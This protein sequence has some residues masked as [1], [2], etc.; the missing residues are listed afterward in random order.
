MW[1]NELESI[2]LNKSHILEWDFALLS[3]IYISEKIMLKERKNTVLFFY[4]RYIESVGVIFDRFDRRNC[5]KYR[6]SAKVSSAGRGKFC[7]IEHQIFSVSELHWLIYLR[8]TVCQNEAYSGIFWVL[9]FNNIIYF[10]F[11]GDCVYCGEFIFSFTTHLACRKI[12]LPN[13]A[14]E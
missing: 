1:R 9:S 8:T 5:G 12:L 10:L 2:L 6:H 14:R 11:E 7:G 13:P 3:W 4:A